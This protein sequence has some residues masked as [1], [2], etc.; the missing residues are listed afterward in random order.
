MRATLSLSL[1]LSLAAAT[2]ALAAE[3]EPLIL[4]GITLRAGVTA[5][6]HALVYEHDRTPCRSG[7]LIIVHGATA[8][9]RSM[10]PLAQAIAASKP[11]GRPMCHVVN[12]DMPGHGAS[13]PPVGALMGELTVQDYSAALIG[14]LERLP[15]HDLRPVS[16]AGHSMGGLVVQLAQQRLLD[17]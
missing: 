7:A 6:I 8:T 12:L 13:P 16:V 3:G 11:G 4:E 10:E 9:A 15:D 14:A 5:D 1:A 17:E 2:P